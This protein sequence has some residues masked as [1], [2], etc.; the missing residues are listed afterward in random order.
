MNREVPDDVYVFLVK[1]EIHAG[2]TDVTQSSQGAAVNQF[3]YFDYGRAVD[4]C[5]ARHQ[6]SSGEVPNSGE[7][8]CLLAAVRKRLF[9][10]DV[11]AT[12]ESTFCQFVMGTDVGC[13]EY[14]ID[15]GFQ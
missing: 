3:L 10:E 15:I 1:A 13:D 7:L 14:R 5:M 12:H 4:K 2:K 9:D 8:G 11:L 6:S